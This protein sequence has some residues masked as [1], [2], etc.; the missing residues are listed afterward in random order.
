MVLAFSNTSFRKKGGNF[1][2]ASFIYLKK[3]SYPNR[4]LTISEL[5]SDGFSA[6]KNLIKIKQEGKNNA[7]E[8]HCQDLMLSSVSLLTNKRLVSI[9]FQ[10]VPTR[11][12]ILQ[13]K[14]SAFSF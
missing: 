7:G 4:F 12:S 8:F 11:T 9:V 2:V 10:I 6:F 3:N 14:Q 5:L 13:G 1:P